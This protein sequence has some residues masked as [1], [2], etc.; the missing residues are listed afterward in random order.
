MSKG[1]ITYFKV[2][3]HAGMNSLP[4]QHEI[5]K[6]KFGVDSREPNMTVITKVNVDKAI[7]VIANAIKQQK[8]PKKPLLT[9]KTVI[10][11]MPVPTLSSLKAVSV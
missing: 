6:N 8:V 1:A 9:K 5:M 3:K 2:S 11:E 10:E 7:A 4:Y